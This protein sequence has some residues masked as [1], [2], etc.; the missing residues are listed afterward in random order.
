MDGTKASRLQALSRIVKVPDFIVIERN[1][2]YHINL[3]SSYQ[4]MVRSS[5]KLE[6]QDEFSQAGQFSTIGPISKKKVA[7]SIKQLF[8]NNTFG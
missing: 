3:D 6:D 8:Q 2:D 1:D 4:Y 5:S 7:A